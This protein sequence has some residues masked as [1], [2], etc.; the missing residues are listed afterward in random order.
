[1]FFFNLY[2]LFLI[3]V[4]PARSGKSTLCYRIL[5]NVGKLSKSG[6]PD[7][8]I[9]VYR[10]E[11]AEL[12]AQ[13]EQEQLVQVFIESNE[14]VDLQRVV[15]EHLPEGGSSALILDDLMHSSK[16]SMQYISRLFTTDARHQRMSVIFIRQKF[17]GETEYVREI[18]REALI[19]DPY[20]IVD[21]VRN[22][23][24]RTKSTILRGFFL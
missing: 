5:Q 23:E 20:K 18:D 22:L 19:K 8:V 11:Q 14:N 17:F 10:K 1:M 16:A 9:W 24:R 21:L 2:L 15:E 7:K 13:M 3:S 4:G 6:K 12:Y